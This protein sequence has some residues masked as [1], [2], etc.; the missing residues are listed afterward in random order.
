MALTGTNGPEAPR[1]L[2]VVGSPRK[3][4][5]CAALVAEAAAAART[6]GAI[7]D[8]IHLDDLNI[9]PCSACNGCR[10]E[11]N[12]ER[13]CVVEDDMHPLYRQLGAMDALLIATPVYWWGP[14]AQTKLFVDRWYGI[15]DRPA[16]FGGK[17]LAII[18]ASGAGSA[19]MAD[20]VLSPFRSIAAYL[21]MA[22]AGELAVAG[23]PVGQAL[24]D[25]RSVARAQELGRRLIQ[26]AR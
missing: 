25:R 23:R 8:V 6:A 3:E 17:P 24:A 2:A 22:W 16:T 18:V 9:R 26:L 21:G 1:L 20:C 19:A 13:R 7:V 11:V 5:N 15:P 14:S 4:G 10:Q 12:G